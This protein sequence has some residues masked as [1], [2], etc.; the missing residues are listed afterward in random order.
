M[1]RATTSAAPARHRTRWSAAAVPTTTGTTAAGRVRGRAPTT[2]RFT[3]ATCAPATPR[4]ITH[5]V[6]R[7]LPGMPRLVAV[8]TRDGFV[9]ALRRAWDRG[10]AV[11][12][13]DNRLP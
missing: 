5:T 13:L 8:E 4:V 7:R 9:D 11:L 1:A 2:H 12:P 6:G 10:D 3:P